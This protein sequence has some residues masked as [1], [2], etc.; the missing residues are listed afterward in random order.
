VLKIGHPPEL[1]AQK[2]P[3]SLV[4]LGKDLKN[5][6]ISTPHNVADALDVVEWNVLVK[7][8][9]HRVNKNFSWPSPVQW[10]IEFF[11]NQSK[12]EALLERV[13]W[14]PPEAFCEELRVA[15]SAA[16]A[17]LRAAS[18]WIPRRIRP[19]NR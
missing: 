6:P 1:T 18:D 10:L 8:V 9:A 16:R 3:E 12:I 4:P 13:A 19:L 14:H 17:H 15:E 2:F 7:E 5:V 11:W